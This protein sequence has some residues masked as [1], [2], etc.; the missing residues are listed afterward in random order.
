MN[1]FTSRKGLWRRVNG[2]LFAKFVNN[3]YKK[4]LCTDLWLHRKVLRSLSCLFL[5]KV[6]HSMYQFPPR[7]GSILGAYWYT[8]VEIACPFLF[9]TIIVTSL[10]LF[11]YIIVPFLGICFSVP[12]LVQEMYQNKPKSGTF[13]APENFNPDLV[14]SVAHSAPKGGTLSA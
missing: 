10:G 4:V 11:R 12:L 1:L 9:G 6:N 2:T 5:S 14:Q 8:N 13:S 3:V 7:C